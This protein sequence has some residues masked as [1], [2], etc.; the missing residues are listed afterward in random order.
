MPI[1]ISLGCDFFFP[2]I[3]VSLLAVVVSFCGLALLVVSLFV[4]WKLCWP[5]WK[6]KLV[7]PNVSALP[8][9]ISSAPTEV[10]ETEEKKEAEENGKPAPKA[11]E[12]AIKISHTSPDIP[13]EVQTALKEHLIK[14]ARVQRQTTEPTSS[15]R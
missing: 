14:H 9:S 11:L 10:F 3:S 8:Q 13:A 4:F 1:D 2:D 12:P 7:A 6:S 5:C 15:S